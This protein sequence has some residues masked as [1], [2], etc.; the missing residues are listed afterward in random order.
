[1][2]ISGEQ[3][4]A[5]LPDGERYIFQARLPGALQSDKIDAPG[6]PLPQ[7]FS[8]RLSAQP[9]LKTPGGQ[10]RYYYRRLGQSLPAKLIPPRGVQMR[11]HC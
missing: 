11:E 4:R 5:G 1:M 3:V 10:L 7:S 9:P 8:Y 6:G 2:C